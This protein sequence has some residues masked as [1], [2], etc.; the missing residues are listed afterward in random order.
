MEVHA[1]THT[2]RKKWTHYL[3]EFLMLFLAVFCGFLAENVREHAV[4]HQREKQFMQSLLSDLSSD[5]AN[6]NNGIP[7]KLKRIAAIDTVFM[8]FNEN[9]AAK[10]ISGKIFKTIR[11]T[12]WDARFNRNTITINQLKNAG[13]MRLI[14]KKQVADSISSYDLRCEQSIIYYDFYSVNAQ[15]GNRQFEKLFIAADLLTLYIANTSPG[16]VANIPDS[17]II[18]INTAELNEQLNFMMLEKAYAL[19]EI[20]RYKDL[21]GRAV[22][23]MGLIK[24]EYQL[25]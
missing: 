9:P 1:H 2:E 18:R 16:I 23:L 15:I 21:E 6:I 7:F 22:R 10:T 19:Q 25:K 3:W 14:R 17:L 13:N 24:K 8:F 5:T 12:N 4:E 20:D 11:R